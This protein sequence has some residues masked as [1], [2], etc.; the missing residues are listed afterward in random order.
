MSEQLSDVFYYDDTSPTGLRWKV[1]IRAGKNRN[2]VICTVGDV[3]G[4]K[5]D[6]ESYYTVRYKRKKYMC[7]RVVYELLVKTISE[8]MEI[9]HIDGNK[10]NN[11]ISNLRE[12]SKRLNQRNKSKHR[13]NTSGTT[14]VYVTNMSK[15]YYWVAAWYDNQGRQVLKRFSISKFGY[16]GAFDLAVKCREEAIAELNTQG[17]GYTEDHGRRLVA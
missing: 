15:W 13:N 16:D 6:S 10:L 11:K 3:A 7:H 2:R 1:T 8:G 14:G 5:H 17:G 12:V 9:D 4:S